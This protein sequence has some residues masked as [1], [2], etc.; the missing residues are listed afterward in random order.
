MDKAGSYAIQGEG[1]KFV[2]KFEGEFD[3]IVGL[4]LVLT[5]KLIDLAVNND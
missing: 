1:A 5:K 3:A 4:G 2:E